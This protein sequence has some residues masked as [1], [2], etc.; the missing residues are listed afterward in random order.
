L[1]NTPAVCRS[2]YIHPEVI[3]LAEISEQDRL[4]TLSSLTATARRGIKLEEQKC[5]KL[6]SG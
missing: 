6:I 3:A 4:A 1:H 2:S 5:L